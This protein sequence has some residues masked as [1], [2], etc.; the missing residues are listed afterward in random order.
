MRYIRT[1]SMSKWKT[2]ISYD[3]EFSIDNTGNI[4][5][6]SFG[7]YNFK[8]YSVEF[9]LSGIFN[10]DYISDTMANFRGIQNDTIFINKNP[11]Y[12]PFD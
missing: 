7:K 8:G 5:P 10:E 1:R 3:L 12:S 2:Q 6:Q 11:E 9:D 4:S